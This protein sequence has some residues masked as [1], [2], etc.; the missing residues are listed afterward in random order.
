M[1][2]LI[3][4]GPGSPTQIC[5]IDYFS[6]RA[7]QPEALSVVPQTAAVYLIGVDI[8]NRIIIRSLQK[9]IAA[10]CNRAYEVNA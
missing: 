4:S 1:S 7:L 5:A 8:K 6:A 9:V 3:A 2:P 10:G